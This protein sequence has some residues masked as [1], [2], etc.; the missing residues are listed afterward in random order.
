[1]ATS[2]D[3]AMRQ[4]LEL[5]HKFEELKAVGA[6]VD[7]GDELVESKP[8]YQVGDLQH[9]EICELRKEGYTLKEI[10]A[11]QGT[12]QSTPYSHITKHN[13]EIKRLGECQKCKRAKSPLST[14][15]IVSEKPTHN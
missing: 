9:L 15:T 1:M 11:H 6:E 13:D 7:H 14:K 3:E 10:A 12:S 5:R 2:I 8:S 4:I